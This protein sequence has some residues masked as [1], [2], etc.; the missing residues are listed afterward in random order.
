MSVY[1]DSDHR[2]PV[3]RAIA[4]SAA[5]ILFMLAAVAGMAWMGV[6]FMNA[7]DIIAVKVVS[8]ALPLLFFAATVVIAFY[9]VGRVRERVF[10]EER[11]SL[12]VGA[13]RSTH[14]EVSADG[15]QV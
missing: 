15:A 6:A 4:G 5:I 13:R 9:L 11:A 14:I 3:I 7:F 10:A 2:A 8:I 12:H 1:I